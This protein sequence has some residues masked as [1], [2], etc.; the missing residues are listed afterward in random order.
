[1][2]Y[3]DCVYLNITLAGFLRMAQRLQTASDEYSTY[4]REPIV[5]PGG[6]FGRISCYCVTCDFKDF[7]AQPLLSQLLSDK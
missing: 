3:V 7:T 6:I 5:F 1:M 4:A 2:V